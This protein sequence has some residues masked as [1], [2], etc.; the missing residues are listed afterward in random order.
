MSAESYPRSLENV[1][2]LKFITIDREPTIFQQLFQA[3]VGLFFWKNWANHT[4][5][6][7]SSCICFTPNMNL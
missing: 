1:P 3:C 2:I 5:G 7:E 4:Q 6:L